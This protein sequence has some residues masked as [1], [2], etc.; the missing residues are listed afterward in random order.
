M[1]VKVTKAQL[2]R[3]IAELESML[4]QHG[5][6]TADPSHMDFIHDLEQEAVAK[7]LALLK[8]CEAQTGREHPD[9]N[10]VKV[11]DSENQ[12]VHVGVDFG[13]DECY[14]TATLVAVQ[15][16]NIMTDIVDQL[17]KVAVNFRNFRDGDTFIQWC[18]PRLRNRFTAYRNEKDKLTS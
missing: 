5:V 1:G 9:V 2:E 10:V 16:S 17:A 18:I 15:H 7:M 6:R 8:E 14:M 3:R 11:T 12:K 4:K 13:K